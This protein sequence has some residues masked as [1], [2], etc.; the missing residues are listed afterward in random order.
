MST[1]QRGVYWSFAQHNI[2]QIVRVWQIN[3]IGKFGL[4]NKAFLLDL[5]EI[6]D[7][8]RRF[9]LPFHVLI[10]YNFEW[11]AYKNERHR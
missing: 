7:N 11:N 2:G 10:L 5:I 3:I 4:H 9:Q 1:T 6:R 8:F